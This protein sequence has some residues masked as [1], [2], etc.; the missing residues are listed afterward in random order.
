MSMPSIEENLHQAGIILPSSTAPAASYANYVREN[1][2]LFVSGKGPLLPAR[3][4]LGIEY[5]VEDGYR[6]ARSAA[7][8]LLAV[9]RDALGSLD[10]VKRVVRLQGF[11]N[12]SP[13]FEAHHLVLDG[14]SDL[15]REAFGER[16]VHARSVM[17]A[18]S[19]R[20]GL[21]VIVEGIFAVREHSERGTPR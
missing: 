13:D 2:Q 21:P 1:G 4:K 14:A 17:G 19:L 3:G 15:M 9:V 7:I 10:D 12:A 16:G 18:S 5:D 20:S 11:V 8:S 6:F